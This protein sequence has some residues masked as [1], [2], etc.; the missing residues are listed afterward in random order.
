MNL[1]QHDKFND[2]PSKPKVAGG[3]IVDGVHTAETYRCVHCSAQ[4]APK[5]GSG[6]RRGYCRNC[7][8]LI[9]GQPACDRCIPLEMM[10]QGIEQGLSTGQVLDRISRM[11]KTIAL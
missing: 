8:G 9:C 3:I 1:L 4:W 7:K 2:L 11:G 10:L 5:P 6:T